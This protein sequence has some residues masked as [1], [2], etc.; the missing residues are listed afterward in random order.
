MK[1]KLEF[2]FSVAGHTFAGGKEGGQ[3]AEIDQNNGNINSRTTRMWARVDTI[4]VTG[5]AASLIFPESTDL[6]VNIGGSAPG[7]MHCAASGGGAHTSTI[8]E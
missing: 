7:G 6:T 5:R 2:L 8:G 1:A 3:Y 4:K